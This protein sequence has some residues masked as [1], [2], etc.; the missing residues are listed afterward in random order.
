MSNFESFHTETAARRVVKELLQEFLFN[1]KDIRSKV[2]NADDIMRGLKARIDT[3]DV[4]L[5]KAGEQA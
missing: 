4:Q 3:H 1:I 5:K 2:S